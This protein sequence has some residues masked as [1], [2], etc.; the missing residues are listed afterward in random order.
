LFWVGSTK[1]AVAKT[2]IP[3]LAASLRVSHAPVTARHATAASTAACSARWTST[4]RW[5]TARRSPTTTATSIPPRACRRPTSCCRRGARQG[6]RAPGAAVLPP[7]GRA[8]AQQAARPQRR[9]TGQGFSTSSAGLSS[10]RYWTQA[11]LD[12]AATPG[13]GTVTTMARSIA[14]PGLR[15]FTAARFLRRLPAPAPGRGR[16]VRVGR[17][18]REPAALTSGSVGRAPGCQPEMARGEST[19]PTHAQ[20]DAIAI[21]CPK[22]CRSR[23]GEATSCARGATLTSPVWPDPGV[24]LRG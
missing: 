16:R 19:F 7:C 15:A 18:Q 9:I 11:D 17:H 12:R 13:C 1:V 24:R 10:G 6:L 2:G 8:G 23:R 4:Q 22:K 20:V 3:K 5:P 21:R 14:E